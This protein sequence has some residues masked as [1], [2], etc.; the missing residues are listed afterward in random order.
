MSDRESEGREGERV[1]EAVVNVYVCVDQTVVFDSSSCFVVQL[2]L[3]A[4]E[5]NL[6]P[7]R[8]GLSMCSVVSQT[9]SSL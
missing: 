4:E 5:R 7:Q 3:P 2:R 9:Y 6:I 1:R 8:S